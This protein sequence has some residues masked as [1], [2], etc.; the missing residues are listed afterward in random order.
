MKARNLLIV[1]TKLDRRKHYS[2]RNRDSRYSG[3]RLS[4]IQE[5]PTPS[6]L[7]ERGLVMYLI[8][9]YTAAIVIPS[10]SIRGERLVVK[11]NFLL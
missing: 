7:F 10:F 1:F 4:E 6:P 3:S 8:Q 11:V 5:P 2:N 9:V